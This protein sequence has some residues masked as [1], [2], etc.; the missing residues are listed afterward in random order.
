M[1]DLRAKHRRITLVQ[2]PGTT[3]PV[4]GH[5]E[6]PSD[7]LRGRTLAQSGVPASPRR[8]PAGALVEADELRSRTV[9][10]HRLP[11]PWRR[12]LA[13]G[14]PGGARVAAD[15]VVASLPSEGEP[16]QGD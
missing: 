10:S 15:G 9:L 1:T 8:E 13:E 16:G 11:S 4:I 2:A 12:V 6:P 14:L 5:A 3:R 7:D